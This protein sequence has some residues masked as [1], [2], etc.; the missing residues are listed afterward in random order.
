LLQPGSWA[1]RLYRISTWL[2]VGVVATRMCVAHPSNLP[3][4]YELLATCALLYWLFKRN[5]WSWFEVRR[6][7]GTARLQPRRACSP[8]SRTHGWR[9]QHCG[10][11]RR[12]RVAGPWHRGQ[13]A[14][15]LAPALAGRTG[16]QRTGPVP[17]ENLIHAGDRGSTETHAPM[18]S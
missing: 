2:Y 11:R 3:W 1:T 6:S 4:F 13:M 14:A 9:D 10:R 16:S 18:Q 5:K 12:R 8:D 17:A 7:A 15:P